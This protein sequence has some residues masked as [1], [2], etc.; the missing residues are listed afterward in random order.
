MVQKLGFTEEGLL[1]D[2]AYSHGRFMDL[3]MYRLLKDEWNER[4]NDVETSC[5]VTWIVWVT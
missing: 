2:Y 5:A 1:H 4:G 3:T